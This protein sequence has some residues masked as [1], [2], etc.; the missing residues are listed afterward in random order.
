MIDQNTQR[1]S[2]MKSEVDSIVSQLE[3]VKLST[4]KCKGLIEDTARLRDENDLLINTLNILTH[5]LERN[6]ESD[7]EYNLGNDKLNESLVDV[8]STNGN[9]VP[10]D[11]HLHQF[12]MAPTSHIK[13]HS[14]MDEETS[15]TVVSSVCFEDQLKA[16]RLK[17][18]P[19]NIA[20]QPPISIQP[21]KIQI[22][23]PCF[24][25]QIKKYKQKHK[26][27]S[28]NQAKKS[29]NPVR[30]LSP[31][32][33]I[34]DHLSVAGKID[35]AS[36]TNNKEEAGKI[37]KQLQDYRSRQNHAFKHQ[38]Q[39]SEDSNKH[40]ASHAGHLK[41]FSGQF[42]RR[43]GSYQKH[44]FKVKRQPRRNSQFNTLPVLPYRKSGSYQSHRHNFEFKHQPKSIDSRSKA[45][46]EPPR[47]Q[48]GSY[49]NHHQNFFRMNALSEQKR[50]WKEHLNKVSAQTRTPAPFQQ[51][52][53]LV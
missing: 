10:K 46:S 5:E 39:A 45:P 7:I 33:V 37:E 18:Q 19:A 1:I 42:Y 38:Y 41:T 40:Q 3:S 15:Q 27:F 29:I 53:T 36:N 50:S 35:E 25:D 16:Y 4:D 34:A 43:K 20:K 6:R 49:Q 12:E 26:K 22:A 8:V 2:Q 44:H 48:N 11:N 47:R 13:I 9:Y 32:H 30:Q 14:D 52:E 21:P 28:Q 17:Q 51:M 23:H 31:N 24:D